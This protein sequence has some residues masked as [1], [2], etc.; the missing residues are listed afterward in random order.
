MSFTLNL[1]AKVQS[2]SAIKWNV[3]SRLTYSD[4][5][6]PSHPYT[7][8]NLDTFAM[9]SL[10]IKYNLIVDAGKRKISVFGIFYPTSLG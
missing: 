4:F 7:S 5:R 9:S 1:N 10:D 3:N 6:A 8:G 2:D